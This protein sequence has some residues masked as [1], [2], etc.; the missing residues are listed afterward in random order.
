[1]KLLI[2]QC[3]DPQMWYAGKVGKHVPYLG[4]WP[5]AYKSRE[6]AGY[7]NIVKFEDADIVSD[8]YSQD[9]EE[10]AKKLDQ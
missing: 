10:T 6:D 9:A 2:K 3:K 4:V 7:V 8:N 1:M 5:E